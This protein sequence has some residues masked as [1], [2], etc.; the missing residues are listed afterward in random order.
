MINGPSLNAAPRAAKEAQL[1]VNPWNA[2]YND[3]VG[4]IGDS[5]GNRASAIGEAGGGGGRAAW[6][7][8]ADKYR[9]EAKFIP[10]AS[11]GTVGF[12]PV[13]WVE[14]YSPQDIARFEHE[15]KI[16]RQ[17]LREQQEKK[18]GAVQV[19][20]QPMT[21]AELQAEKVRE[22]RCKELDAKLGVDKVTLDPQP[23][24]RSSSAPAHAT[25]VGVPLVPHHLALDAAGGARSDEAANRHHGVGS[26]PLSG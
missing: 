22:A 15:E 3:R 7:L 5:V 1:M 13:A 9:W 18:K 21:P 16:A 19:A 10:G 17:R 11:G 8:A 25:A 23:Q 6:D 14:R 12:N 24:P 2:M 20:L 4:G 26:H